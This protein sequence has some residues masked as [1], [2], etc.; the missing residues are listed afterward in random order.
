CDWLG[1]VPKSLFSFFYY[2]YAVVIGLAALLLLLTEFVTL[3]YYFLFTGLLFG[4]SLYF[5]D[6]RLSSNEGYFIFFLTFAYLFVPSKHRLMRWLIVSFFAA[7]GLSQASPDWLTG[8][9]YVE[10]L[11][12]PIK[13]GE[14]FAALSVL[15]QMIGSMA[16]LFRDGRYFWSGWIGLF[17]YQCAQLYVGE[18]LGASLGMGALLYILFDELELRKA[19]REYLYQSFIRP[20]PTFIWGGLLLAF[21]WSA[22]ISPFLNLERTSKVRTFLDV[23]ALHPEAAHEDCDQQTYAIYKGRAE[24]IAVGPQLNRQPAMHCNVYMRFLDLKAT[25]KQLREADKEFETLISVM[26]V[27]NYRDK[28]SYRAFEVKDFCNPELTF[29]RLSEAQWSMNQGK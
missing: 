9:W 6:L 26:Q 29:N 22:Q 1:F 28:T 15:V 11:G 4:A 12:L 21:F 3:G 27:R 25:C 13:L 16:L 5:Q 2:G 20:E 17:L 19:E 14:W 18:L 8:N 10:H 24:E 7:R 23:W